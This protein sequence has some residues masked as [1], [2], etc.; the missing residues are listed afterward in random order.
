MLIKQKNTKAFT[1]V[2]TLISIAILVTSIVAPLTIASS[3]MFQAR[4]SRDQVTA[5][6]LAQE[7]VEMLR[8]VRDHNLMQRLS[9]S[10]VDWLKFIPQ[11]KWF[12][13][14]WN[15]A[16]GGNFQ[17]CSDTANPESCPYLRYNGAYSLSPAAQTTRFKR[18]VR[19][20]T[21][22]TYPDEIKVESRVYWISG[23][24]GER[25]VEVTSYLYNWAVVE[26]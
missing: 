4:Y 14:D 15:T 22:P 9:G 23:A 13:P 11:N 16:Q 8:Y 20:V 7:S 21:N 26:N 12:S 10:D 24:H 2:E 1:L 5:T 25:S 17:L 3:S 19:I 6:Y 18:A